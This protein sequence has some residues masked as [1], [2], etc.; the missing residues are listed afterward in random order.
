MKKRTG[1]GSAAVDDGRLESSK[2]RH[3]IPAVIWLLLLG[4]VYTFVQ[5]ISISPLSSARVNLTAKDVS[6]PADFAQ[7]SLAV[8]AEIRR[9][10]SADGDINGA[11]E[12]NLMSLPGS[13]Y[14]PAT[15]KRL[16]DLLLAAGTFF[17]ALMLFND[18]RWIVFGLSAIAIVGIGVGAFGIVQA[19][20]FNGRIYGVYELLSGGDPFGPFV[21]GNNAAGFLLITFSASLFFVAR[22]LFLWNQTRGRQRRQSND[23]I[24]ADD[25]QGQRNE[26]K[27][28]GASLIETVAILQPQHLYF[29]AAVA[30]IV[31]G[32][33]MT[34][35][36]GGMVAL[37]AL[38]LVT[39]L[40]IGRTHWKSSLALVV[41]IMVSGIS[42]VAFVDR[43]SAI[44]TELESFAEI[45]T[46]SEV[47]MLHWQDALP[48]ALENWVWGVGNGTYRY[49]SP[50]FQ[51]FYYPRVFA[52]AE[53]VYLET[54][55]EMGLIGVLL[56]IVTIGLLGH[57]CIV[58]L[59]RDVVFDRSLG[60]AGIGC[61]VGQATIGFLDFGIYQAPNSMAAATLF[62]MVAGRA[63]RI[64]LESSHLRDGSSLARGEREPTRESLAAGVLLRSGLLW[65]MSLAA[66]WATYESWGI[67]STRLA[68]RKIELFDQANK[69]SQPPSQ[70]LAV[71]SIASLL[72][73]AQ[74]IRPDD[75][76]VQIELGELNVARARCLVVEAAEKDLQ[77][78]LQQV[79]Q[80][81][82]QWETSNG[83]ATGEGASFEGVDLPQPLAN[84]LNLQ[85]QLQTI[86]HNTLWATSAPTALHQ[87]L[88]Q[89][90]RKSAEESSLVDVFDA[91]QTVELLA[92]AY[93]HFARAEDACG[94]LTLPPLRLAQL[95]GF[96]TQH[97]T[98]LTKQ[99]GLK[100]ERHFIAIALGRSFTDTQ[101]LYNCGFIALNSGNQSLAVELWAKC[102]RNPHLKVHEQA[103]VSLCIQEMPMNLFFEQV[104]P[105]KPHDLIRIASKYF[106]R[107]ELTLPKRIL[108]AHTE[109][110]INRSDVLSEGQRSVLLAESAVLKGQH[111][112]AVE[113]FQNAL[114]SKTAAVPWRLKYARSLYE[115]DEFDEA[116]RQLKICQ[117]DASFRQSQVQSL[118]TKIRRNR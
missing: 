44:G 86:D 54:F 7:T 105:Q 40:L 65:A 104:L 91:P 29:L 50:S 56:L 41:L 118:L 17:A 53:S 28:W 95:A 19:L 61:L 45:S 99:D 37:T 89:A 1:G 94:W 74:A 2:G 31:A 38:L 101:L 112:A 62:A 87:R 27:S 13:V 63:N 25:W 20:S 106:G 71:D 66:M 4:L 3:R 85:Q 43:S 60:I 57:S 83:Q 102:L 21:N 24:A 11:V 111:R 97:D 96:Y 22:Q 107:P 80:R 14:P 35:S 23:L 46:A 108:L 52:H 10:A 16:V 32:V 90:Q 92:T 47:R 98:V 109:A 84:D 55:V 42:L 73:T 59:N 30:V 15:R 88:R 51:S 113:H 48:F 9:Q 75:A 114:N 58:L 93:L 117:L 77:E 82:V 39:F 26:R 5:S 116:L 110:L 36:R 12:E 8:P 67:E 34:L 69:Q 76:K 103:I 72:A 70:A 79:Q 64:P 81:I 68:S 49:V 78:A 115:I 6:A 33:L 18:R 100:A